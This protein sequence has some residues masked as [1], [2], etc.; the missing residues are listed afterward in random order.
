I[1]K[2][3][4][5]TPTKGGWPRDHRSLDAR[6]TTVRRAYNHRWTPIMSRHERSYSGAL[7]ALYQGDR[8]NMIL[9]IRNSAGTFTQQ[10]SLRTESIVYYIQ[11]KSA[12]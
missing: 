11:V 1:I 5:F 8:S 12:Q 4:F 2:L 3:P 10:S 6:P 7:E 9:P